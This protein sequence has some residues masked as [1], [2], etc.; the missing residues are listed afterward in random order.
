MEKKTFKKLKLRNEEGFTFKPI[1]K[2]N[3]STPIFEGIDKISSLS[4]KLMYEKKYP[5]VI[6]PIK[7]GSDKTL[8]IKPKNKAPLN[9]IKI[10]S[11]Q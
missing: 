7:I 8:K 2:S 11:I 6:K 9:Q 5:E 4:E 10:K 1:E 3:N